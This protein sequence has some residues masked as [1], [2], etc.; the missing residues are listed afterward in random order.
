V[1]RIVGGVV[2]HGV[3]SARDGKFDKETGIQLWIKFQ[4]GRV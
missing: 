4:A 1:G 2:E 3:K